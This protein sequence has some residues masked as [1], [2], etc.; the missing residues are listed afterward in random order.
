MDLVEEQGSANVTVAMLAIVVITAMATFTQSPKITH[1]SNVVNVST[2]VPVVVQV[3]DKRV[4]EPAEKATS[5]M[6]KKDVRMLT[7]V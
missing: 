2:D 4:V 5:W 3:R 6:P 7:N 1:I